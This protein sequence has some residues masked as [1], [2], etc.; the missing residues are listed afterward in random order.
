M[1]WMVDYFKTVSHI[2]SVR[3]LKCHSPS[4]HASTAIINLELPECSSSET[5]AEPET[6]LA[7]VCEKYECL[8]A[9]ECKVDKSGAP[10][11]ECYKTWGGAR[12]ETLLVN[13]DD[14]S[15]LESTSGFVGTLVSSSTEG[16]NLVQPKIWTESITHNS[17]KVTIKG[18]V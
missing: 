9:G 12:C 14:E 10:Y 18:L 8:H 17:V 13:P 1:S 2:K 7:L 5:E 4:R 11:C 6:K 16:G 15:E 3:N